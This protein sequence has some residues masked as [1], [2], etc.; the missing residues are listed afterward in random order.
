MHYDMVN[1]EKGSMSRIEGEPSSGSSLYHHS[2]SVTMTADASPDEIKF[3]KLMAYLS[4]SFVICWMPQMVSDESLVIERIINTL[5]STDCHTNGHT[6]ESCAEGA[7]LLHFGR[8]A[9]G[10]ALHLGPVHLCAQPDEALLHSGLLQALSLRT[11][12]LAE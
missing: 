10:V 7:S 8:C 11:A 12:T 2:N 4:I 6:T 3:A 9:D 5:R 1:R